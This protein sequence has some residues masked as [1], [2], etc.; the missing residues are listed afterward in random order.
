M[1]P[2][3]SIGGPLQLSVLDSVVMAFSK[4]GGGGG[5]H[6]NCLYWG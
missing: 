3:P 5:G 6:S 1:Y 4:V 2:L